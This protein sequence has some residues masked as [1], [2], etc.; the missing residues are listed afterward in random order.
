MCTVSYVSWNHRATLCVDFGPAVRAGEVHGNV[1]LWLEHMLLLNVKKVRYQTF[2]VNVNVNP[3]DT[4]GSAALPIGTYLN[5]H[6]ERCAPINTTLT[7]EHLVIQNGF[8]AR[9]VK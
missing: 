2:L 4:F 3:F 6:W 8:V 1:S 7:Y 9:H 5:Y